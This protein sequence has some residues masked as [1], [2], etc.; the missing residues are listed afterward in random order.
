MK[1]LIA[2]AML[3]LVFLG[4]KE[5]LLVWKDAQQ[6][7]QKSPPG[8]VQGSPETTKAAELSGLP[9][10][11][12]ASLEASRR[13][14]P[15]ALRTWLKK[16]RSAVRDP[17]LAD[18]ELDFVVMV[19]G[20]NFGEAREVFAEVKGRVPEDSPVYSRVQRLAKAYE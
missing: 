12:A 19:A 11:L 18:I 13:Q 14:G 2:L 4:I 1:A 5:L 20:K 3:I 15:D 6:P 16:N 8:V 17:R 10:Y 9:P 7:D